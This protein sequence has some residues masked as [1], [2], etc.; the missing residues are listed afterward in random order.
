M[1]I[2]IA[3]F[4][5]WVLTIFQACGSVEDGDR[6]KRWM[7][8]NGK[9]KILSTTAMI[10]D[11]ASHVGGE[12]VDTETLIKGELDPHSYQLVKGDDEK[13]AFADI[14]FCNG[15]GLEH[16]PSLR[17]YLSESSK[18]VALGDRIKEEDPSLIL[19]YNGAID[20][21]IWMDMSLWAKTV[22][23][24]VKALSDHDPAHAE[25]YKKNGEAVVNALLQEH[26]KLKESMQQVPEK[27]R[28]LVTSH[29]AFNYF[30]R[31][32]LAT[33]EE[34]NKG[35]WQERFAAPE[36]LAPESQLSTSDIRLILNHIKKYHIP[37]IFPESN[38]SQAS[39][40]KLLDAGSEEGVTL[41]IASDPLYGD[42][43]GGPGSDGDTYMKM[44]RH[45]V[46]T[47]V[48]YLM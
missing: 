44:I 32:Y 8:Q 17:N 43:M 5:L 29:D 2:R 42:A 9:I 7:Q 36:G 14:I 12:Y 40:R 23:H 3:V 39:I 20:P 31:V 10:N 34:A 19:H 4:L 47:I 22:K 18:V 25:T 28:Y 48:K 33:P 15:L 24:M 26:E 21:H 1:K 45:N 35:T 37:V 30:A 16:G 6:T 38:V 11:I 46:K 41:A 13:L 27:K